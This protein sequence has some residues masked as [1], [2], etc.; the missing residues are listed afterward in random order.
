M[1]EELKPCEFCQALKI[2][3]HV[4]EIINSRQEPD[5]RE[6]IGKYMCEC[7]V[8][9][10]IH[11]WYKKLGKKTAGRSTDYRYRGLGYKLNYCPECGKKLT[12][13]FGHERKG[14]D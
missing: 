6:S 4:N 13:G 10:V 14:F 7:T 2:S 9:L 3:K 1:Q 11:N 12:G 8:A 5:E